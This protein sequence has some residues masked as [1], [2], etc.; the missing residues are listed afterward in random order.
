[1]VGADD[2]FTSYTQWNILAKFETFVQIQG[3]LPLISHLTKLASFP[4]SRCSCLVL[5]D[6]IIFH[7]R[8]RNGAIKSIS[9]FIIIIIIV[10]TMKS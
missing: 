4:F 3:F 2:F 10:H 1:M 5:P 7:V 8:M 9:A 6:I